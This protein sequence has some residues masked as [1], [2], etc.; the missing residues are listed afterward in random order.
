MSLVATLGPSVPDLIL[1][2]GIVTIPRFARLVRGEVLALKNL[3]F[4]AASVVVGSRPLAIMTRTILPNIWPVITVQYALSFAGAV[5]TEAGLSYLGLGAQ[6]PTPAWGSML[7][8]ARAYLGIAPLYS[9]VTGLAVFLTVLSVSL[10]G[11]ALH[12]S[13]G[14]RVRGVG[15]G[16]G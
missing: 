6:P 14:R 7:A 8:T 11:D 10:V 1:A 13:A 12:P 5:L 15:G 3:Q 4:V 16:R 9:V 2:I